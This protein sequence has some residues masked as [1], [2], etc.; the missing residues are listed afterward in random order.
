MKERSSRIT[1]RIGKAYPDVFRGTT[2]HSTV[3][4]D[5][6]AMKRLTA[7]EQQMLA[8]V[9]AWNDEN[10]DHFARELNAARGT[11]AAVWAYITDQA[12][13]HKVGEAAM[14]EEWRQRWC[15]GCQAEKLLAILDAHDIGEGE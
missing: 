6:A 15:S 4:V 12:T 8:E 1:R 7:K 9:A 2:V 13:T 11:I 3:T 5:G 10:A 14:T